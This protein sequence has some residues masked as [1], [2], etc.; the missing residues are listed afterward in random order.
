LNQNNN[1]FSELINKDL[2]TYAPGLAGDYIFAGVTLLAEVKGSIKSTGSETYIA[3]SDFVEELNTKT[4]KSILPVVAQC[5][6]FLNVHRSEK[7]ISSTGSSWV[8]SNLLCLLIILG[9]TRSLR[10]SAMVM[11]VI[12][13]M[14]LCLAGLLFAIVALPFGPVEALGVSIFIGLSANYSLH[15]VHAYAHSA[16]KTREDKVLG[17]MFTTG[18]P[19]IASALSTIAGCMFLFGCRTYVFLELGLLICCITTLAL[20]FSMSFL[21]AWLA[22]IGPLPRESVEASEDEST[23]KVPQEIRDSSCS[24][25]VLEIESP[26]R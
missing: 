6:T 1:V 25:R 11:V 23:T 15:M 22:M 24:T 14:F 21:P 4:P 8:I 16:G 13:L 19:I 2:G 5:K 26:G 12:I 9:F 18:S 3:W 20:V 17:A 10:L 7:T